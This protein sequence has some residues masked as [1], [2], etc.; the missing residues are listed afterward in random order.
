MISTGYA[1]FPVAEKVGI[2]Q[3]D[4]FDRANESY[5]QQCYRVMCSK[6]KPNRAH[7]R[8]C[9]KA[10]GKVQNRAGAGLASG[11]TVEIDD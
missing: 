8:Q 3:I 4:C 5:P 2:C 11:E 1:C 9:V 7:F 6:G 10:S